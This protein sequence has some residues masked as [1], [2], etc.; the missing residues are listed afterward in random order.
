VF[1]SLLARLRRWRRATYRYAAQQRH[2]EAWLKAVQNAVASDYESA[3]ALA[4]SVQIV[5]GYGDTY[6]R[7][8]RRFRATISAAEE[9][10]GAGR[11]EALRRLRTAALA[12]EQ[13]AAFDAVLAELR[14]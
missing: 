9:I 7:G 14:R 5:R 11:A 12:D 3:V 10:D 13:G 1:L 4:E 6:E 2:I 8:L